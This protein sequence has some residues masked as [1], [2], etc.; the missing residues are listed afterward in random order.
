MTANIILN[1]EADPRTYHVASEILKDLNQTN[2]QLLTNNPFKISDLEASGIKVTKRIPLLP[3][4]WTMNAHTDS[5]N[6]I[7]SIPSR[8]RYSQ[9]THFAD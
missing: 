7:Y 4:H 9:G 3:K 2:I 5:Q 1:H 6:G 8:S